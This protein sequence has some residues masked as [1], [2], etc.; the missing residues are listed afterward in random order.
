MSGG[1][2]P[3][4]APTGRYHATAD[5]WDSTGATSQ[6]PVPQTIQ[7]G[8]GGFA[9][10]AQCQAYDQILSRTSLYLSG[11]YSASLRQHTDV[12]WPRVMALWAVPDVY[13]ARA[14]LSVAALPQWGLA[15]SAGWR[16]DGTTNKDLFHAAGDFYRHAG[17]TMYLEPGL[18]L[19]QGPNQFNLTVPIRVR[20]NYLA[21]VQS[22]QTIPGVGG[23]NDY[24]IYAS[25]SRRI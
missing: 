3:L 25:W 18:S 17:Y 19:I 21:L 6:A 24:V 8:D 11:D 5:V 12:L 9:I 15:V 22:T 10:L 4:K 20:A 16:M 1:K 13:S 7:Q 2:S 14:G 23:V